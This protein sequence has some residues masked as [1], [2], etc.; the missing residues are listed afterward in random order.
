MRAHATSTPPAG[1]VL[2]FDGLCEP[3]NP[4]GYACYG[5]LAVDTLG[6]ILASGHG[7]IGRGPGSSNNVAEY[8]ALLEALEHAR[9]QGWRGFTIRGDSLLVVN[10]VAGSWACRAAHLQPLCREASELAADLDATLE[11]V[12]RA[13]NALADA[14]SRQ[15]YDEARQEAREVAR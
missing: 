13:R 2:F 4:G 10:Q 5:W 1:I 7:C 11:W 3:V 15:A 9:R 14:L 6:R 12:P 8:R